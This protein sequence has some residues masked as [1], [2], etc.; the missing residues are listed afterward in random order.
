MLGASR[1]LQLSPTIRTPPIFRHRDCPPIVTR[2]PECQTRKVVSHRRAS[3]APLPQPTTLLHNHSPRFKSSVRF[4]QWCEQNPLRPPPAA[5]LNPLRTAYP[6]TTSSHGAFP[7]SN[8][9]QPL[10][11]TRRGPSQPQSTEPRCRLVMLIHLSLTGSKNTV[12]NS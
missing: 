8:P 3:P 2:D 9:L 1:E 5:P 7:P 12:R 11:S 4:K 10:S 6:Q